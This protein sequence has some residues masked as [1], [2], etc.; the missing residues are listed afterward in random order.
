MHSDKPIGKCSESGLLCLS[1]FIKSAFVLS[2]LFSQQI[3]LFRHFPHTFSLTFSTLLYETD[4]LSR[5]FIISSTFFLTST[6]APAANS[7][8]ALTSFSPPGSE[9]LSARRLPFISILSGK[10]I[11]IRQP[12]TASACIQKD[13]SSMPKIS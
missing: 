5:A 7:I 10:I 13:A 9:I 4:L 11:N 3:S 12:I 1:S 6:K 8:L 2:K